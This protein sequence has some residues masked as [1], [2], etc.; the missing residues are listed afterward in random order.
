MKVL[1]KHIKR[2]AD[3]TGHG[4]YG[5]SRGSRK[6]KGFDIVSIPGEDVYTPI[7]GFISKIGYCYSFE[8]SFRYIEITND[9]YRWRLMY[10]LPKKGLFVGQRV[11][12][13]DV[14]ST[15]QDIAAYWNKGKKN[16]QAKMINHVHTQVWKNGLL[17]D[18]EPLLK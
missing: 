10:T 14:V 3:P 11:V 1:N 13:G 7:S 17:T 8:L 9:E 5:K 16:W 2:G 18:P 4:D 12:E 15:A 6:H